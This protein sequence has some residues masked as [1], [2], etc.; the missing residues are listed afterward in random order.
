[1][2][3]LYLVCGMHHSLT[4]MVIKFLIDNGAY[5]PDE[6]TYLENTTYLTH[7]NKQLQDW[8]R[9]SRYSNVPVVFP[10]LRKLHLPKLKKY[11]EE[12]PDGDIFMKEPASVFFLDDIRRIFPG[13]VKVIYVTRSPEQTMLSVLDKANDGKLKHFSYV[14]NKM[15]YVHRAIMNWSGELHTVIAER[16]ANKNIYE[17]IRLLMYCDLWNQRLP[18]TDSIQPL[19]IR[20]YSYWRYRVSNFLLKRLQMLL[21]MDIKENK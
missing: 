13:A 7:E 14:F 16:I 10:A 15:C 6:I 12:L 8:I 11:F 5:A 19:K 20:K 4:S 3:I 2:K 9:K 21:S 18:N 1:M 17:M